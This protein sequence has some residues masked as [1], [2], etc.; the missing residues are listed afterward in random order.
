MPVALAVALKC[1]WCIANH[2]KYALDAGV[3]RDELMEACALA[4]TMAGAPA[5]MRARF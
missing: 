2:I 3:S 1:E 5:L 4:I